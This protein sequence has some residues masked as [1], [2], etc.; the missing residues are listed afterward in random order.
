MRRR[1]WIALCMVGLGVVSASAAAPAREEF[2]ASTATVRRELITVIEA[3]LEAFREGDAAKAQG[4]TS[5]VLRAQ[6][7]VRAFAAIVRENYPEIWANTGADFG[8]ARDN[9]RRASIVAR[10]KGAERRES[11]DFILVRERA[12]WRIEAI[13]RREPGRMEKL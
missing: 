2:A 8:V 3:Q 10:V 5:S 13:L 12:G 1:V 9:G 11:Y 4:L 7:S 6:N